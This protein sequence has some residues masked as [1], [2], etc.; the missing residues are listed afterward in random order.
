[1][2][3]VFY[4][5]SVARKRVVVIDDDHWK[6]TAMADELR[7]NSDIE[8]VAVA[9]QDL[10][11]LWPV[12]Q[13]AEVDLAIVDVFDENAP[14]E[15]GTDVFSGI[16]VLD[17]LR[18]LPV[19]TLAITPHCQHPLVQLRIHQAN[20]DWLYHRW[21]VNGPDQLAAAV[22]EPADDHA[23]QRPEDQVLRDLGARRARV[24]GS[25]TVYL[26]S[27]L[28]GRLRPNIEATEIG[29]RREVESFRR[30]IDETGFEAT[31]HLS[32]ATRNYVAPRWP[33][34][35]DF[36]LTL[37]GRRATPPTET[38]RDDGVPGHRTP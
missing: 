34:V 15:I 25:V 6:R 10:A 18:D 14:A 20:A 2:A 37:L 24:N 12:E 4:H 23:P 26:R 28:A 9:D 38:D 29:T 35:R 5:L 36:V 19:K 31:E 33:D 13:W 16:A 8:V 22:L 30:E 3:A 32:T 27:R 1:M 21:E 17:A 11:V 7:R